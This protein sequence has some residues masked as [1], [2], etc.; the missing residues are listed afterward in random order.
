MPIQTTYLPFPLFQVIFSLLRTTTVVLCV[1][2]VPHYQHGSYRHSLCDP[3]SHC[4]HELCFSTA[5][6]GGE[7]ARCSPRPRSVSLPATPCAAG[8]TLLRLPITTGEEP[9]GRSHD[10]PQCHTTRPRGTGATEASAEFTPGKREVNAWPFQC[11]LAS[12]L[13]HERTTRQGRAG[14]SFVSFVSCVVCVLLLA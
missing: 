8:R 4:I 9:R 14:G 3:L 11:A 5:G 1:F 6:E 7:R 2:T 13:L 12:R 10:G